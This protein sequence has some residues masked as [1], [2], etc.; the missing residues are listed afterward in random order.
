MNVLV[1][2]SGGREHALCA[3]LARSARLKN[4][5]CLPGNPGTAEL[6]TNLPGDPNDIT[7][8][9]AAARQHA[10]DLTVVGPEDPLAAGIVDAFQREGLRI[11]GPTRAA[12]RLEADKSY[13]KQVMR[14]HAIPTAESRTFDNFEHAREYIST[15]DSGVVVKAAGLAKGKGVFVCPDPSDAIIAA[16]RMLFDGIFGDAGRTVVVEEILR[17]REVSVLAIVSGRT[18]YVLDPAQDYKRLGEGDTGPNTGGM[19]SYSPSEALDER[20]MAQVE[21]EILVPTVNG[22]LADGIRYTG[23][24]YAGLMLTPA[25]PKVLEFNCRFGDPETQAL[26]PRLQTDLLDVIEAAV[27]GTLD[28]VALRWDPRHA[29]CV[30]LASNGYPG[31]YETGKLISGLPKTTGRDDLFVF[32]AGTDRRRSSLVTGGGRVLSVTALAATRAEARAQAY[33][34]VAEI[35]F[36]GMVYRK[37]LAG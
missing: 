7:A 18:I 8:V 24:L 11:F 5:F 21:R 31:D 13:A 23:V 25:G 1:L 19:G 20:T 15:R 30:V 3:A 27:D 34:S 14:Q 10:I 36:A 35:D 26:L 29:V 28:R 16:E 9:L 37:D 17:G 32:H 33:A 12:A 22:L 4:L 2:G 6:G